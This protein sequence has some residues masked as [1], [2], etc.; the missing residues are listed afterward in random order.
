MIT[1]SIF[2]TDSRKEENMVGLAGF[3]GNTPISPRDLNS[4]LSDMAIDSIAFT[5]VYD[6]GKPR[7][8]A[9]S[10]FS[11]KAVAPVSV[12]G[13]VRSAVSAVK[14]ADARV[15]QGKSDPLSP[16]AFLRKAPSIMATLKP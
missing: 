14:A 15:A 5:T 8:F 2:D 6:D 13:D 1:C 3:S 16:A 11:P 4:R 10:I 12:A 7:G 9:A